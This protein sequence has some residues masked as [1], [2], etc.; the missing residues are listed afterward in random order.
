MMKFTIKFTEWNDENGLAMPYGEQDF[1]DRQVYAQG[2][3]E[4]FEKAEKLWRKSG[5]VA[6]INQGKYRLKYML[7]APDGTGKEFSFVPNP[8]KRK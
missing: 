3:H 7:F 5:N 6:D 4:A 1:E 8:I 2:F